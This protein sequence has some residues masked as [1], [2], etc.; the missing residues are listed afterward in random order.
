MTPSLINFSGWQPM[1]PRRWG[2]RLIYWCITALGGTVEAAEN[3]TCGS[4]LI[5]R[6]PIVH[7]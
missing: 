5:P 2:C 1:M 4:A 7:G 3:T 6:V